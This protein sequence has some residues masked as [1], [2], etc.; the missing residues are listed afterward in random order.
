MFHSAANHVYNIFEVNACTVAFLSRRDVLF[1]V[2]VWLI[3]VYRPE[4][5]SIE[6]AVTKSHWGVILAGSSNRESF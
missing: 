6:Y 2:K 3:C 5:G 4:C 1:R